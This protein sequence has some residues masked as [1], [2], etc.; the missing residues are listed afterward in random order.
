VA[1]S[2]EGEADAAE[3]IIGVQT[4]MQAIHATDEAS[5]SSSLSSS[6]SSSP[7]GALPHT[8]RDLSRP[9]S[10]AIGL[11]YKHQRLMVHSMDG[12]TLVPLTILEQ[13]TQAGIATISS[14][15]P[16]SCTSSSSL[17]SSTPTLF[18][19]PNCS[20]AVMC[21]KAVQED[22]GGSE[23]VIG[24]VRQ[25]SKLLIFAY[26]AYG[27]VMDMSFDSDLRVLLDR[28]WRVSD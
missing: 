23:M 21:N 24:T 14:T 2:K 12:V 13:A 25:P 7:T 4:I 3:D 9:P 1:L 27:Q 28:G 26:G 6:S 17:I 10:S 22:E 19:S 5:S 15:T 16:A 11:Q 18:N 8:I 20:S